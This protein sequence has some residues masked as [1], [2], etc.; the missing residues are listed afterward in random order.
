MYASSYF[1]W[2]DLI[3]PS[4]I[5]SGINDIYFFYVNLLE[6]ATLFFVRTR[7][8]IKYLP[9]YITLLNIMFIV[10]VNS[11]MYPA[12]YEFFSVVTNATVALFAYFLKNYEIPAVA[13]VW[14]PFGTWT[15]SYNNPRAGY[16]FVN[17]E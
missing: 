16:H 4:I 8:S 13:G 9:K 17:N 5:A 12:Q 10:Y 7:S 3:F 11:Y 6:F 1:L 2:T 14:S 15:P